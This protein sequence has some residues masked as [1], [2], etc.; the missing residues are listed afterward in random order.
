[1]FIELPQQS[2][3]RD[4]VW[5]LSEQLSAFLQPLRNA[6]LEVI[7]QTEFPS[8][9]TLAI[10]VVLEISIIFLNS[11]DSLRK[12]FKLR[13]DL[14]GAGGQPMRAGMRPQLGCFFVTN[15]VKFETVEK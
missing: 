3:L 5:Y 15:E 14:L 7:R 9:H 4:M 6:G 10:A 12:P 11:V 13:K 2:I 8:T 1:M